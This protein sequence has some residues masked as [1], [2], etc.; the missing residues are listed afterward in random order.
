MAI[1]GGVVLAGGMKKVSDAEQVCPSHQC[2][3]DLP[4]NV[5]NDAIEKGNS[6]RQEQ[7]LGAVLLGVGVAAAGGGLLWYF[8]S[9]PSDAPSKAAAPLRRARAAPAIGPGYAGISLAGSF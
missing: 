5:A 6:G 8:L 2:S 7:V 1:V 4:A 3:K 9:A